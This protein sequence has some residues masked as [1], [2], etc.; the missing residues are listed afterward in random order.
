[1]FELGWSCCSCTRS[2]LF[3]AEVADCATGGGF[4]LIS[5]FPWHIGTNTDED[6]DVSL[7]RA[8]SGCCCTIDELSFVGSVLSNLIDDI[9]EDDDVSSNKDRCN[10]LPLLGDTFCGAS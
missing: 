3:W 7:V 8:S 1:M 5:C 9:E 10:C 6:D 4:S 2:G